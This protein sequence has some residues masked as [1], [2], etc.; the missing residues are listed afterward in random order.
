MTVLRGIPV[1]SGVV[2][3]PVIRPGPVPQIDIETLPVI[4]ES[5]R[6]AESAKFV[7]AVSAVANRLR[8]RARRATGTASQVLAATAGLAEDRA[9]LAAAEKRIAEGDPAIRATVRAAGQFIDLF[10]EL[11]GLMAERVTDL[12]DIRDRVVAE[13]SGL[14]E[15]GVPLPAEPSVLCAADLAPAATADL[16]P[17]LI[18]GLATTLGGPTSHTAIIARQLGMPCVVGV[19][20][21]DDVATGTMVLVDGTL[22]AV[23][24]SPDEAAAVAAVDTAGET[25]RRRDAE[26]LAG[27]SGPGATADGHRVEVLANVGD[28][29]AARAA[30]QTPAEG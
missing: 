24:V 28:G 30:R 25:A 18:T 1:V 9:W 27:W 14:P 12:Q 23:T 5:R 13:L 6:F 10:G 19:D 3:A 26:S 2:Y 21:L 16:D 22:G 4:D 15:P 17:Q 29:A 11:G 20:G 7:A 8:E